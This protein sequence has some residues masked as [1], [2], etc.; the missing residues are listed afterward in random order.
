[1][2]REQIIDELV[3]LGRERTELESMTTNMLLYEL[4]IERA[5]NIVHSEFF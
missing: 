1:M 2:T 3:K 5:K 4:K